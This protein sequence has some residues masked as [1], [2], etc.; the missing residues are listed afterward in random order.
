[1]RPN[2]VAILL[3][4]LPASCSSH[5]GAATAGGSDQ[6]STARFLRVLQSGGSLFGLGTGC[7]EWHAA[8]GADEESGC[9]RS[10]CVSGRLQSP[11]ED[12]KIYAFTYTATWG[13][14]RTD[15]TMTA[16]GS[17]RPAPGIVIE[18]K[19]AAL[20]DHAILG[21]ARMCVETVA[22][23][24]GS[25]RNAVSV[26]RDTWYLTKASCVRGRGDAVAARRCGDASRGQ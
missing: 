2:P 22:V 13:G 19:N 11:V 5:K 7:D 18:A 16:R 15:L 9:E 1:V 8:P 23:G 24:N 21:S 12:G 17:W 20:P 3:L 26:G 4:V 14:R 25:T 6:P 10:S